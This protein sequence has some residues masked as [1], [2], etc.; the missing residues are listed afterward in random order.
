MFIV[1]R[2]IMKNK[3]IKAKYFKDSEMNCKCGH[4]SKGASSMD[5][6]VISL[7][8]DLR[9]AFGSALLVVS[10]VRCKR[11]NKAVGGAKGSKHMT[12]QALD[13]RPLN[14]DIRGLQLLAEQLNPDGGV[15]F[16]KTFVHID[17]RGRRARWG[18]VRN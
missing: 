18:Y 4:C 7:A 17:S 14:G 9:E 15:G 1:L 16:Y 6:A 2:E 13:L 12:G 3:I 11:H 8:D 5:P 10:A